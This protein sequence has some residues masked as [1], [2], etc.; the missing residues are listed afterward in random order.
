MAQIVAGL[1][2]LASTS[3][4][5]AQTDNPI[6]LFARGSRTASQFPC[7]DYDGDDDGLIDVRNQAQ[8]AAITHDL[9]GAGNASAAAYGSA[10]PEAING[11]G[12]FG[13]CQGYELLND[14]TLTGNWTPIGGGVFGH[15]SNMPGG[16]EAP[17]DSIRYKS[18]FDGKGHTISG[19]R[20]QYSA[21][22]LHAG[23]FRAL[24][25]GGKIRN[26]G[27]KDVSITRGTG[28]PD[29]RNIGALVGYNA[30]KVAAS[31]AL[32][33]VAGDRRTGGLVGDNQ[34]T[35]IASYANVI[36]NANGHPAGGLTGVLGGSGKIIASYALGRM[37]VRLTEIFTV[38]GGLVG[39][40]QSGGT[41]TN[42]YSVGALSMLPDGVDSEPS[43]VV[44]PGL[45]LRDPTAATGIYAGWTNLN[46]DDDDNDSVLDVDLND[47]NP[48]LF[49]RRSQ[50]PVL[51]GGS[52]FR[53][54][55]LMAQ[56]RVSVSLSGRVGDGQI[57]EG[58]AAMY[59]V[60]LSSY[61]GGTV[62]NWAV[63]ATGSGD[64]HAT[65]ADF[66]TTQGTVNVAFASSAVF[67]VAIKQDA[68]REGRESFRVRISIPG[69]AR[70]P[71]DQ[72]GCNWVAPAPSSVPSPRTGTRITTPTPTA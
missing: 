63:E 71:G 3:G 18:T 50:F 49:G 41:I 34:G 20:I 11:M 22:Y 56:P 45:R 66:E 48:W 61:S 40:I 70:A 31:Y 64:G 13:S 54:A 32:G 7:K 27:L 6:C 29:G 53:N 39:E 35:I 1:A 36:V 23:L 10:F 52:D 57:T 67:G 44:M 21:I 19:L 62:L 46:V 42:S 8:L 28:R 12:C 47:D 17:L 25:T 5:M 4:A 26:V 58:S 69:T 72:P 51:R 24:G 68:L 15:L 33:S 37:N 65:S 43:G 59:A 60:E 16:R 2:L 9:T 14:I 38:Y 55:Q 30:G